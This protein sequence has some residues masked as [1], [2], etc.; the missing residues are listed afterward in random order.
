MPIDLPIYKQLWINCKSKYNKLALDVFVLGLNRIA[1]KLNDN[2]FKNSQ[3][4]LNQLQIELQ[5]IDIR[6]II[7]S[8]K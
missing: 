7:A 2:W 4:I 1:C 3:A 8:V 6:F 5:S